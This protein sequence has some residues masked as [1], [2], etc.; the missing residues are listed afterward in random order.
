MPELRWILLGLGVLFCLVLWWWES[1][2]GR[3]AAD[4][5]ASLKPTEGLTETTVVREAPRRT[6]VETPVNRDLPPWNAPIAEAE[7]AQEL[8][9]E[10]ELE[11]ELEPAPLPVVE[12][13]ARSPVS[14]GLGRIE[15]IFGDPTSIIGPTTADAAPATP[16]TPEPRVAPI[17]APRPA[18]AEKIVTLRVAAPPLERFEGGMLVRALQA[19]GLEHGKFSIF[20]KIAPDGLTLF[21]V[22]SLVEPG[23][24]DLASIDGRRFPGVSLFAVL[25]SDGDAGAV[26]EEMVATAR[27][28]AN[29]LHGIVQD[30]R[31]AP[32]NAQRLAELR[33]DVFAWARQYQ[34]AAG[35]R[36]V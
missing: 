29:G 14:A 36:T 23:T 11:L 5:R 34:G 18:V 27:I 15:P 25:L 31:G 9:V 32:L 6:A 10:L 1:R 4:S 12:P 8:D 35:P 22:A 28:L 19:A 30:E 21:S 33:A 3:Q 17:P 7:P 24:F 13:D 16:P 20:H 26:L 2:R